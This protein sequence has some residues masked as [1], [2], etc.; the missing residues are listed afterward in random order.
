MSLCLYNGGSCLSMYHIHDI[1]SQTE[2]TFRRPP[3][4][5]TFLIGCYY[6]EFQQHL[7]PNENIQY[8]VICVSL[9]LFPVRTYIK[10]GLRIQQSRGDDPPNAV[11]FNIDSDL[12]VCVCLLRLLLLLLG[13]EFAGQNGV[14]HQ[15]CHRHWP[16]S[17][18]NW[19]DVPRDLAHI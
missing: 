19:S 18:G 11:C 17:S 7:T 6:R 3:K 4:G 16:Y 2:C 12:L 1:T 5:K 10:R 13:S 9:S 14:L 15:H 8:L